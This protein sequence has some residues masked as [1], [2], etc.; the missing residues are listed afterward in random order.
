MIDVFKG[1][2]CFNEM[3]DHV[4]PL[5]GEPKEVKKNC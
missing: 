4:L 5:K 1:N 3:L 2:D